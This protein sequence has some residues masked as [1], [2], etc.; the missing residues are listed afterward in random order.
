M[1]AD[2]SLDMRYKVNKEVAKMNSPGTAQRIKVSSL[3]FTPSK[4]SP[5]LLKPLQE[6]P[7]LNI[8]LE[9]KPDASSNPGGKMKVELEALVGSRSQSLYFSRTFEKRRDT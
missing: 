2:G 8:K 6:R 1:K 3:N 5:D 7:T 4:I 9:F